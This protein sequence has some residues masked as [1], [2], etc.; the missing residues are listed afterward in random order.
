M[1]IRLKESPDEIERMYIGDYLKRVDAEI[2]S[3]DRATIEAVFETRSAEARRGD[4]RNY[5]ELMMLGRALHPENKS[6]QVVDMKSALKDVVKISA[7]SAVA[8]VF[9]PPPVARG[10]LTATSR[11]V[12]TWWKAGLGVAVAD[13]SAAFYATSITGAE[14]TLQMGTGAVIPS[15]AGELAMEFKGAKNVLSAQKTFAGTSEELAALMLKNDARLKDL[16]AST[17]SLEKEIGVAPAA[18]TELEITSQASNVGNRSVATP[19]SSASQT[20]LQATNSTLRNESRGASVA[21]VEQELATES[22]AAK[23]LNQE[24]NWGASAIKNDAA[25]ANSERQVGASAA[26]NEAGA[27]NPARE[28]GQSERNLGG[29]QANIGSGAER[30]E[31]AAAA[32]ALRSD[33]AIARAETQAASAADNLATRGNLQQILG[34]STSKVSGNLQVTRRACF[35]AGTLVQTNAGLKAIDQL[36]VGERVLSMSEETS[37]ITYKGVVRTMR[38][39]DKEIYRISVSGNN[40]DIEVIRATENHPFWLEGTGWVQAGDLQA[41]DKLTTPEGQVVGVV[42]VENESA[43]ETVYNI[44]VADFH[45]YFVGHSQVLVHNDD[46]EILEVLHT[47]AK[48]NVVSFKFDPSGNVKIGYGA[49]AETGVT[50]SVSAETMAA[51]RARSGMQS[52]TGKTGNVGSFSADAPYVHRFDPT[53]PGRPDP[54]FSLDSMNF[55]NPI[56]HNA[57]GFPRDAGKFW[58]QWIELNPESISKNNRYLIENYD[59]LKVSPR[60][61]QTW[62]QSFPE[63][64]NYLSDVL[65]H[66]HVDHGKYTIPVP[67]KT[68]VGSGG[69]WHL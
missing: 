40:N 11:F 4:Y 36:T 34:T 38:I 69:P 22:G 8:G 56:G 37:E 51:A 1:Q 5:D 39:P 55:E 65:I 27:T 41:D 46:C 17:R 66:H 47:R 31:N 7:I 15:L 2:Q 28:I 21:K 44:E 57:Q 50:H 30:V 68:H 59:R 32:Q 35:V 42:A 10:I 58:K 63:H 62:I 52:S 49:N 19:S 53:V 29:G 48:G 3:G 14:L 43:T 67:G 54:K 6:G 33:S 64:G 24:G 61:D 9:V 26:R 13:Q 45:T 18:K 25:L 60:V 16:A 23:S 12:G 20:E